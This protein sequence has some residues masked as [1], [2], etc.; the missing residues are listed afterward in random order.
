MRGAEAGVQAVELLCV[1]PESRTVSS[2]GTS[3]EHRLRCPLSGELK[4]A[5]MNTAP[6]GTL[7]LPSLTLVSLG[8]NATAHR[9]LPME[10]EAGT[11][12]M[13]VGERVRSSGPGDAL[14]LS[15]NHTPGTWTVRAWFTSAPLTAADLQIRLADESAAPPPNDTW[16]LVLEP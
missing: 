16:T 14:R 2:G 12:S 8:P 5:V 4:V 9:L 11:V 13:L 3:A 6:E 1:N 7:P 15:V 10:A